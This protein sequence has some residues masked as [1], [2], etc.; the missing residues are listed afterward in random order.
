VELPEHNG[1]KAC[2]TG[3]QL[4]VEGRFGECVDEE[5]LDQQLADLD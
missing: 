4:C 5:T 2:F 3:V 1:V